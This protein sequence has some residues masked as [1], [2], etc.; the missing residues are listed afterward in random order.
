MRSYMCVPHCQITVNFDFV[1]LVDAA[2]PCVKCGIVACV[3]S[4]EKEDYRLYF[5]TL[6][7]GT[8]MTSIRKWS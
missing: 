3:G 8:A 6:S 7:V 5:Y 4:D 2:E 1:V